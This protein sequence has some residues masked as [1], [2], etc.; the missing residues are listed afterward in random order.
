[1]RRF[2]LSLT[3]FFL[4]FSLF[5][6]TASDI[7]LF[8][9][10]NGLK[11]YFLED[12]SSPTVRLELCVNAGF[13][14]Q[15]RDNGGLFTMY[16]RLCGGEIS[17]D[18]V[19]FVSKAAPSAA[20]KAVISLSSKLKP[21]NISDFELSSI[22]NTM[23][24][25]NAEYSESAAGFINSAIDSKVFAQNPWSR[26]SGVVPG[27]F[28]ARR[29]EIIRSGLAQISENY[30]IPSNS[31]LFVSGNITEG[32]A[33]ALVKKYFLQFPAGSFLSPVDEG[34]EKIRAA[35]EAGDKKFSRGRKFLLFHKD[36]SDE[37]TQIV[38]QYTGLERDEA[39]SLS[40][41]WNQDG[42]SFKKLLLKQ[43][44]LKIL[45]DEYIDV[46]SAQEKSASRLIIQSLLGAA[47]VSPIVQADLFLSMSRDE[48]VFSK[49]ELEKALKKSRT[50]FT[51]LSESSDA[52]M[53]QFSRTV[54]LSENSATAAESFFNKIDR[55]S[56]IEIADLQQKIKAEDPF[57][58]V[59]VN[60]AVYQKYAADFKK[61][62]FEAINQKEA[63]WYNQNFYKKILKNTEQS[64]DS[65]KNLLEEIAASAD[66]FISKNLSDYSS[67][68]LKNGI[69]VT[70]KRSENSKTAVLSLTIAGG[71]LLFAD[72]VPGL[73]AVVA[74]SIAVNINRQLDLFAE[75]GAI[76][77]FYEVGA[78]TLSTHSIIT[79]TCLSSE[80]D[81]AIQAA[82]T[83]LVYCDIS[84][85]T[86]DGVTYDERTQ[87]RLKTGS[88][89][90]QLLCEA[91][92]L[93]YD[94]TEYPKLYRDTKDKPAENLE[95]T[96]ILE[97]YPVL[98]DSTRFSL[99]L[100]GGLKEDDK[101]Q[102]SLDSSFGNLG[103]IEET[104][105][106]DLRIQ[107][108]DF[109]RLKTSEKRIS[110]RHLFLTDIS[111]DKAGPRPAVLIPTTKFL[112]PVLY[113]LPSPD[114]ASV[115]CALFNAI[116]IELARR[117]EARLAEKYPEMKVKALLPEND[118]PFARIVVTSVEHTA[119]VDSVYADS[120]SS[121]KKDISREIEI[122]TEGVIDLEK[123]DLLARLENNW[124][125]AVISGAGSQ[126][127]TARLIQSGEIQKNPRLYLE[128]YAAIARAK[129]EDYFLI[130]ES[131]FAEKTP[132]RLYSKDSKK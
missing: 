84:P 22:I 96:R 126:E 18:A 57:V 42:A 87:W 49:K 90:F 32:A 116:L 103:S 30:Y 112:D 107:A 27:S 106:T 60:S 92:R 55:L 125:M 26:E 100:S 75:N 119:E 16:A 25:E 77:G 65:R 43:R 2:I 37:M 74:D 105:S 110:L 68:A 104:R 58:F 101:L 122:K 123:S 132:L 109:A 83:A 88:T 51:R 81:L 130:A 5:A 15:G 93:L 118:L 3:I 53:E 8:T 12:S 117:M 50:A 115:D 124:L 79:V 114:L 35:I 98:L 28:T 40:F 69:P 9:L 82:Y 7:K 113:C 54:S 23:S 21:L 45:G 85:A 91:V 20:E 33:L 89:E 129:P 108:P 73:A 46:S 66:R 95:F 131:Y 48:D 38:V 56:Q 64:D 24:A 102:K 19:R 10:E 70:V 67:F 44:N 59:F 63:A 1:M 127:G 86:A 94:G 29:K 62:G 52:T 11:V 99:I 34:A 14:N 128:Q 36:F 13:T 71:E 6:F 121:I 78:Q 80:M 47:K 41:A 39:D 111:K 76:S 4:S 72:K 120:I 17:N 97:A 61:A 31:V